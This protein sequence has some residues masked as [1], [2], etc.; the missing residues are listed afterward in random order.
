MNVIH[1]RSNVERVQDQSVKPIL[2]N[3]NV[4]LQFISGTLRTWPIWMC[5]YWS[6]CA[7]EDCFIREEG[8]RV[9]TN[10]TGGM[11]EKA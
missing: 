7:E 5:T 3:L 6:K 8:Q 11:K 9:H 2:T 1:L 4:Q 10:C